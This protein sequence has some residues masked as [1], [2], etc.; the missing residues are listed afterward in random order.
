LILSA[1]AASVLVIFPQSSGHLSKLGIV[2]AEVRDGKQS[3]GV[4]G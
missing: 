4:H 1:T 3:T 2:R